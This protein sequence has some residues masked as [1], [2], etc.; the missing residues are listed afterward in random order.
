MAVCKSR[1]RVSHEGF[2]DEC[3]GDANNHYDSKFPNL[4]SP[5]GQSQSGW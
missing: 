4:T 1:S 2:L 3:A 5:R